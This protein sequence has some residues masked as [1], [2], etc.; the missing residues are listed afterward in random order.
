M[1]TLFSSGIIHLLCIFTEEKHNWEKIELD[2][3]I[4]DKLL[5]ELERLFWR[6]I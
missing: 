1:L 2:E 3:W 5:F 6:Q 4:P